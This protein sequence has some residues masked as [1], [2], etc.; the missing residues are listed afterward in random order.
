MD[1]IWTTLSEQHPEVLPELGPRGTQI[2]TSLIL[3]AGEH[4]KVIVE[5]PAEGSWRICLDYAQELNGYPA[6]TAKARLLWRTRKATH[7]RGR[8]FDDFKQAVSKEVAR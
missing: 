3:K 2:N 7:W 1:G 6:L 4:R 5:W 8:V